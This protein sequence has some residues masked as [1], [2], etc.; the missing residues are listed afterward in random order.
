MVYLVRHA[1]HAL[2]DA[3]LV[4]RMPG[5]GLSPLGQDQARKLAER[6][7]KEAITAVQ[8]SPCERARQT[9]EEIAGA[10]KL[11]V[12]IVLELDEIDAGAW[13]GKSFEALRSDPS[14]LTWNTD[15]DTAR[16]PGGESMFEL[17]QRTIDHLHRLS[18]SRPH[19]RCVLVTHAEV[20]RA[21]LLHLLGR[22]LR[23]FATLEIAPASV[24][25]VQLDN[26]C[27]RLVSVNEAVRP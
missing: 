7:A 27:T 8:S 3:V 5:V 18:F 20:I 15:R 16:P 4:G 9:A 12:E 1:V 21:A 26:G 6:F 14:W 11:P 25:A 17:Q 2:V 23:S 24:S 22:P 10:A 13:T 19:A